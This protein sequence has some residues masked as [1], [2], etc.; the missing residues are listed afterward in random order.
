MS[1]KNIPMD[2]ESQVL[3]SM[4][5]IMSFEQGQDLL[6]YILSQCGIYSDNF[7][8]DTSKTNYLLGQRSIGLMLLQIMNDT[9]P[10]MYAKLQL[11]K[12]TDEVD[13]QGS[14]V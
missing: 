6:W 13:E 3:E 5:Y 1:N 14:G 12:A 8:G 10:R 4:R 11:R 7:T 2:E 9:D